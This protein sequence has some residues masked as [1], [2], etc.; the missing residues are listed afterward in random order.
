MYMKLRR[1]YLLFLM[2]TGI[3]LGSCMKDPLVMGIPT[4]YPYAGIAD[5]KKMYQGTSITLNPSD[6][7]G[8][9]KLCGTVVS[10][11][12]GGNM[13]SGKVAIQDVNGGLLLDLGGGTEIPFQFG[14][15]VLVEFSGAVLERKN[16]R[17]QISGL[18]LDKVINV[19][20]GQKPVPVKMTLK[21]LADS[22]DRYESTLVSI[23]G[24]DVMNVAAGDTYKGDYGLDDGSAVP[25]T[26]Q[27]HTEQGAV[28]AG[29]EIPGMANFTGLALY[30]NVN[31][32][33]KESA[34]K[35]IW[36]RSKSD[37]AITGT[38]FNAPVI[39]T[40]FLSDS[41]GSDCPVVGAV[42]GNVVHAGGYEYIQFMALRDINFAETPF[43]VVVANN[44]TATAK[45]WAEGG[46]RTY[47]FNLTSGTA[48]KGTF[49]YV[50][51][52]S[53]VIAGYNAT[54]GKS[55]DISG[56]NWIRTIIINVGTASPPIV[57][58]D[59]FGDSNGG[60]MGNSSPADGIAI[61]SGTEVTPESIPVDAVFY[62]T[63]VG[64]SFSNGLGYLIP[65]NDHYNKVNPATGEAQPYFGQGTN[66]YVYKQ[67]N[68][69]VSSFSK[70]G[71][72]ITAGSWITPRETTLI[73]L[74]LTA[75]L[76]DIETAVGVTF[77]RH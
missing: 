39:I 30:N 23:A 58:G 20:K 74:P 50:G 8:L 14:D 47:K 69:D 40:G 61:F 38:P 75:T 29:D 25:G 44:G 5:M 15:S 52:N 59:G 2:F 63:T 53:K 51:A 26:V 70:L 72:V 48:A 67:P 24:A 45:G 43:S 9:K 18:T 37:V 68:T 21:S 17:L 42:S 57:T 35:Q 28:F 32:N 27:L 56:A 7:K 33:E 76:P 4:P 19:G 10:D 13:P 54:N 64:T 36:M 6:I 31:G 1:L 46:A 71:G 16:G 41:R 3:T 55:T 11:A 22:F 49:F 65:N 34:A 66:T 60:F 73:D 62:G 77:F 12:A